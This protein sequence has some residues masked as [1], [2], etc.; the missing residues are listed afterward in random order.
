MGLGFT[1]PRGPEGEWRA[2]G[3]EPFQV[4]LVVKDPGKADALAE[5]LSANFALEVFPVSTVDG[6]RMAVVSRT[7]DVVVMEGR[8]GLSWLEGLDPHPRVVVLGPLR[9]GSPPK[10]VVMLED[11][12]GPVGTL[13][14]VIRK[15]VRRSV[16][17]AGGAEESFQSRAGRRHSGR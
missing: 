3:D 15:A 13:A 1:V 5:E 11:W 2:G 14:E 6:A 9:K 4:L 12:P 10:D 8:A 17:F 7:Y 16:E